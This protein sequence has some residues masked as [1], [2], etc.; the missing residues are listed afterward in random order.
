MLNQCVGLGVP[1][2]QFTSKFDQL[3]PKFYRDEIQL[4]GGLDT[5]LSS[6]SYVV[7]RTQCNIFKTVLRCQQQLIITV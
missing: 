7:H 5:A 4:C 3:E 2:F 6:F 1:I